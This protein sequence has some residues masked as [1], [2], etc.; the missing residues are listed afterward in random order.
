M[1][2]SALRVLLVED[3]DDHAE[4]I[5]RTLSEHQRAP[6]IVHIS[7]GESALDYLYRRGTWND[8]DQSPRPD[9]IL[10][11]LRLPRI[12][13]LEVLTRVKQSAELRHI[14]VIILTSSSAD[15]DVSRAYGAHANSYLVKPFGFEELRNLMHDVGVYW[16]THNKLS[17]V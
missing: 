1:T 11:D 3:N 5:R 10:L 9:V 13:G 17:A 6:Q 2:D 8:P 7:D 14:P 16:L 4:L 12:D 15:C